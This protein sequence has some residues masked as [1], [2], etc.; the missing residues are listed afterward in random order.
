MELA[1][2]QFWVGVVENRQDPLKV[3][4]CQ[5]RIAG[6]HTDDKTLIPTADLPWAQVMLPI[7]DTSRLILR[8]GDYVVGFFLDGSDAQLPVILGLLPGIPDLD[9]PT[10]KGFGDPRTSELSSAPRPP[11]SLEFTGN[12]GAIKITENSAASRNPIYLNEPTVSRLARNESIDETMI[13]AKKDLVFRSVP[14]AGG[15]S[16]TEPNTAYNATYPY[17]RVIETESGHFIELDDTPGAERVH[18]Y[19]RSGTCFEIAP[20]GTLVTKIHNDNFQVVLSDNNIYVNG[21]C[22]LTV[23]GDVNLKTGGNFNVEVEKNFNL[24]VGG[25]IN[26]Q[27]GTACKIQAGTE[28]IFE[29]GGNATIFSDGVLTLEGGTEQIHP[30]TGAPIGN[31]L[32]GELGNPIKQEAIQTDVFIPEPLP[33]EPDMTIP[34]NEELAQRPGTKLSNENPPNKYTPPVETPTAEEISLPPKANTASNSVPVLTSTMGGDLMVRAMNRAKIIDPTQRAMIW[35][36]TAHESKDFTK[37]EEDLSYKRE[38]LLRIFPRYFRESNVNDYVGKPDKIASHAYASRMGNGNESSSEGYIYRG[39]GFIQL[40]G[41]D[42]YLKVSRAFNQNFVVS[43][44]SAKE[45]NV[46][47]DIAVWYFLKGGKGSGYKKSY[48]D[49]TEVT[50]F[51]NGGEIGLAERAKLFEKAKKKTEVI[52]FQADV[53]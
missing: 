34:G 6:A 44:D 9:I 40:T 22:N 7:T 5:V 36:Q 35:A 50:K 39:R 43:P 14:V 11:K 41:K 21:K 46:A 27:S 45:P 52:T 28:G 2:R 1:Y 25:D 19:H 48:S 24:K 12:E 17:N 49:I 51:V 33:D 31:L 13:Q 16:F 20:T 53:V 3:G 38:T 29:C 8:E 32:L 42:N 30:G 26:V 10:N 15:G 37:L 47:A 23:R 18:I 4:R